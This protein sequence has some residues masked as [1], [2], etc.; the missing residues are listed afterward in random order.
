M[1]GGE[2]KRKEKYNKLYIGNYVTVYDFSWYNYH[3]RAII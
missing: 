2:D 1:E 3:C